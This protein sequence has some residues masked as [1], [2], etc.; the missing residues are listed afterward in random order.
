VDPTTAVAGNTICWGGYT[1]IAITATN[2]GRLWFDRNLGAQEV[3][4]SATD[5]K[6]YGD[7]YQWGRI[8]DGHQCTSYSNGGTN[9]SGLN[10]NSPTLSGPVTATT[11]I[12]FVYNPA[13]CGGSNNDWL[14]PD[15]P[16][17][18][19]G[20]ASGGP[21]NPCP[22]GWRVP[23]ATELYTALP[24]TSGV[25]MTTNL[26]FPLSG[27]RTDDGGI[28]SSQAV[29]THVWTSTPY[30]GN[31]TQSEDQYWNGPTNS[32]A[33]SVASPA[34]FARAFGFTVRCIKN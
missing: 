12:K 33:A 32:P 20:T 2:G 19:D 6:A 22:P 14:T 27:Y 23:I 21:Y 18:W 4:T 26:K 29:Q 28:M 8:G 7:Y 11:N 17:L 31:A 5:T 3:A 30:T 15:D 13:C 1:Y 24:T 25:P 16:T 9:N 34:W 10:A